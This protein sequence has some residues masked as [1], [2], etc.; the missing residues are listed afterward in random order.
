MYTIF[1][2]DLD[3][4]SFKKMTWILSR[5]VPWDIL[6]GSE[7]FNLKFS[8]PLSSSL[9]SIV[10]LTYVVYSS[11]IKLILIES[12]LKFFVR[13]LKRVVDKM[14]ICSFPSFDTCFS[15]IEALDTYIPDLIFFSELGS[16]STMTLN[17]YLFGVEYPSSKV[18]Y[19]KCF[20]LF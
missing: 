1:I 7:K 8:N 11:T 16:S 18:T 12:F 4:R 5:S 15:L 9:L 2:S 13:S 17:L 19:I 20:P 10:K 3:W 6:F 14:R